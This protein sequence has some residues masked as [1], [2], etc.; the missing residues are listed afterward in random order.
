[1]EVEGGPSLSDT[2]LSTELKSFSVGLS[3]S[4]HA[5]LNN[6]RHISFFHSYES[7]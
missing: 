1:M 3:G 6:K 4:F 5:F 7:V 2:V